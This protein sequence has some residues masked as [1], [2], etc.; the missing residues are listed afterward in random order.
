M[1]PTKVRFVDALQVKAAEILP[2]TEF[3]RSRKPNQPWAPCS[4]S[5]PSLLLAEAF[6]AVKFVAAHV[7]GLHQD[8]HFP[9]G[10]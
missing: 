3:S 7:P 8:K 5:I 10:V 4:V 2:L 1:L 6:S 9:Q